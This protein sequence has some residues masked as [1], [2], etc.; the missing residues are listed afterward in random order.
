MKKI[1]LAVVMIITLLQ[2]PLAA[3]NSYVLTL[4]SLARNKEFFKLR[5]MI[6]TLSQENKF[7]KEESLFISSILKANFAFPNSMSD[8]NSFVGE[9]L[10]ADF[11]P[12]LKA[13]V[14]KYTYDFALNSSYYFF[15]FNSINLFTEKLFPVAKSEFD[16]EELEDNDNY[17]K[18]LK[19]LTNLK[20]PSVK[21]DK[22]EFVE[23][24]LDVAKLIN[25]PV[26]INGDTQ[27]FIF[28]SGA[29]L[30]V[31]VSSLAL[32]HNMKLFET[33]I[34]VGTITDIKVKSKIAIC[35]SLKIGNVVFYNSTFLVFPD[36][37]LTFANGFYKIN[38]I[39]GLPQMRLLNAITIKRDESQMTFHKNLTSPA[40]NN[41]AFDGLTPVFMLKQNN[42]TLTFT[43][44]TGSQKTI[45]YEKYLDKY[46]G[47]IVGKYT[48]TDIEVGGAGGSKKV[49][50]YKLDK[51][52]LSHNSGNFDINNVNLLSESLKKR[53]S[54]F[55]GNLGLDM[56]WQFKE[57][58]INFANMSINL[59]N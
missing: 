51:V 29:N 35:D 4:D 6:N 52:T 33:D 5:N 16:P 47:N 53:N 26:D 43:F 32:K 48:E 1:L 30:P 42:D 9:I 25:L 36:E 14:Y 24:Y 28:D 34:N 12:T 8:V 38:G 21:I 49:K 39:I 37:S 55:F 3:Q 57:I 13:K 23:Y 20:P 18:I 46:K 31:I 50:G 44:D 58:T 7:S 54:L 2:I 10:K 11:S 22:D 27:N 41:L 15:D 17:L 59:K 40:L 56:I 19:S 45:L